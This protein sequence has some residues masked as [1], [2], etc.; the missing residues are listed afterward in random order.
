VILKITNIVSRDEE[1]ARMIQDYRVVT[2]Q[3]LR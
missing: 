3:L 1:A 2:E